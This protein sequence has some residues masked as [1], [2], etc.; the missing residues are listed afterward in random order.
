VSYTHHQ[1]E[2]KPKNESQE[3]SAF[4]FSSVDKERRLASLP[5]IAS[6]IRKNQVWWPNHERGEFS[7]LRIYNFISHLEAGF[8]SG[9]LINMI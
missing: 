2:S 1:L 5:P 7:V 4:F 9:K 6:P 3:T 8:T